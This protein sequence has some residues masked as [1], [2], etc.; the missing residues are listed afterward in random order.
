MSFLALAGNVRLEITAKCLAEAKEQ[1]RE[2]FGKEKFSLC[3][4][5][6]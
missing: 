1:A 2:Y 6:H 4:C 3:I 5:W